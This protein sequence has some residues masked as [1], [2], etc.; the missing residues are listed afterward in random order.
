MN[1][2]VVKFGL[3]SLLSTSIWG[4]TGCSSIL[5]ALGGSTL[6]DVQ[7][8][9]YVSLAKQYIEDNYS[10]VISID[11]LSYIRALAIDMDKSSL[12]RITLSHPDYGFMHIL[13]VQ[14]S[15]I[16]D[17][18]Y[19]MYSPAAYDKIEAIATDVFGVAS[20]FEVSKIACFFAPTDEGYSSS[21]EMLSE[22]GV[23]SFGVGVVASKSD[24]E[25]L[26]LKF[27]EALA[28]ENISQPF[29][30]FFYEDEHVMY[31]DFNLDS[32][33]SGA[34]KFFECASCTSDSGFVTFTG[35]GSEF[36]TENKS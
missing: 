29:H 30:I 7:Q 13:N 18:D 23:L 6:D 4:I 14:A 32:C 36:D 12:V 26:T 28:K 22:F 2:K 33:L 1:A 21:D 34:G 20:S 16:D 31:R 10:D 27:E 15:P 17:F 11:D 9:Q 35:A 8:D 3:A 5:A 25:P 24:V 19:V